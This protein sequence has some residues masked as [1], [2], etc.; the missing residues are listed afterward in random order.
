M[1]PTPNLTLSLS[2]VSTA[3]YASAN[4]SNLAPPPDRPRNRAR[5]ASSSGACRT[6]SRQ[7]RCA[8]DRRTKPWASVAPSRH[9]STA[10]YVHFLRVVHSLDAILLQHF[11]IRVLADGAVG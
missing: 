4:S 8:H 3:I 5:A 7:E 9:I 10:A 6:S 11:L 1:R 2:P